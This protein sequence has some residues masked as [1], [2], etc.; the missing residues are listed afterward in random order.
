LTNLASGVSWRRGVYA[1]GMAITGFSVLY[2][3]YQIYDERIW[4]VEYDLLVRL[5]W[6][7]LLGVV[8][9]AFAS[10]LLALAWHEELAWAG[11][12]PPSRSL[13]LAI[14]GRA[15]LAKYAPGNI[16][17]LVGRQVLGRQIG[18]SHKVL[19]WASLFEVI[20]MLFAAGLLACVG[21]S[22]W[23]SS[24]LKVSTGA[25]FT[26]VAVFALLPLLLMGS[27]RHFDITR[28]FA[29]PAMGI[30]GYLRLNLVFLL[31]IPFF[32]ASGLIF[33]MLVRVALP[34]MEINWLEIVGIVSAI[35]LIGYVTP[36]AS[37]GI[38][39]RDAL[40]LLAIDGL[41]AGGGAALVVVA[42]RIL[43]VLGDIGFFG[44]AL[45]VRLPADGQ[46]AHTH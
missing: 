8:A 22:G 6:A 44:L 31:Y 38:G 24:V 25:I 2:V 11:E 14:Y 1:L 13:S 15:Q 27:L 23:A 16:F 18:L 45:L 20:G 21:A 42:Y 7:T 26:S 39:V 12:R 43:T 36:G 37:A 28:R 35:W 10:L 34:H 3:I 33:A 40:L 32:L 46:R 29:L 30:S 19:A 5:A 9:Y 4:E 41:L 17:S